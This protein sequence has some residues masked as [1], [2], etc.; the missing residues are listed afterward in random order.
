MSTN[1]KKIITLEK[2]LTA[3][4]GTGTYKPV[5]SLHYWH[6]LAI[7]QPFG[8]LRRSSNTF[9]SLSNTTAV[10]KINYE[11]LLETV[12]SILTLNY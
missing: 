3:C 10:K 9:G 2:L 6:L 11:L 5:R 8:M 12:Y 1:L 7:R 4:A